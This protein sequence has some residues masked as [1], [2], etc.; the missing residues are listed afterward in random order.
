MRCR[1]CAVNRESISVISFSNEDE[2]KSCLFRF[3]FYFF[4]VV[5]VVVVR[6]LSHPYLRLRTTRFV[7]DKSWWIK[8]ASHSCATFSITFVRR[9]EEEGIYN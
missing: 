7:V 1:E 8:L 5:V 9:E 3:S 2:R 6:N 4:L